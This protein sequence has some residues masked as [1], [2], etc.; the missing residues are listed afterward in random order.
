MHEIRSIAGGAGP[1]ALWT[2]CSRLIV[3]LGVRRAVFPLD[4]SVHGNYSNPLLKMLSAFACTTAV[5]DEVLA[6][7]PGTTS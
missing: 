3:F 1:V 7:L 2:D 6:L 4:F 5:P